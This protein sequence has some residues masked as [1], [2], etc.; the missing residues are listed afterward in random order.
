MQCGWWFEGLKNNWKTVELEFYFFF[1]MAKNDVWWKKDGI[2]I[3]KL[4]MRLRITWRIIVV[5]T[6]G[7]FVFGQEY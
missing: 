4:L 7:I 6:I 5:C 3:S 1:L 2:S